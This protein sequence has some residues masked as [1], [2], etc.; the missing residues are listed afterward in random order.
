MPIREP[1]LLRLKFYNGIT[2]EPRRTR[3]VAL[4]ACTDLF[5]STQKHNARETGFLTLKI[6]LRL[7]VLSCFPLFRSSCRFCSDDDR[8]SV[9]FYL[10]FFTT[11]LSYAQNDTPVCE[12]Q[13]YRTNRRCSQCNHDDPLQLG[14]V[15]YRHA[16]AIALQVAGW[17]K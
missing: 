12:L 9:S 2:A 17:V 1:G 8:T 14:F 4:S 7:L 16:S 15:V 5:R 13:V 11:R 3:P 10:P 6:I